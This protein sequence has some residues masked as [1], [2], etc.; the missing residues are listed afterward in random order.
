MPTLGTILQNSVWL[1]L[2]NFFYVDHL[3]VAEV[4]MHTTARRGKHYSVKVIRPI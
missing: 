2:N 1:V 4:D 3:K